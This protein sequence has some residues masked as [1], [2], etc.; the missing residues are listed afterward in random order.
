MLKEGSQVY[1][2]VLD[3]LLCEEFEKRRNWYR[4]FLKLAD[5]CQNDGNYACMSSIMRALNT[6]HVRRLT[7]T[8]KAC[9]DAEANFKVLYEES[10]DHI[11]ESQMD[12]KGGNHLYPLDV[13][14]VNL[15]D[16]FEAASED[17][18]GKVSW[19]A[20]QQLF[21]KLV[22]VAKL[23]SDP[24]LPDP[25][26]ISAF[27]SLLVDQGVE[28]QETIARWA[29]KLAAIDKDQFTAWSMF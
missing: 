7:H 15:Q 1:Y 19:L 2:W 27:L 3:S 9:K 21:E 25:T 20:C 18:E 4:C 29:Q 10:L 13:L 14:R 6:G 11:R 22:D 17:E 12:L 24:P 16:L 26:E 5:L 8:L 28:K 23:A